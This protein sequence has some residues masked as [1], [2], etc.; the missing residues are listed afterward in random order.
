MREF[1]LITV[2]PGAKPSSFTFSNTSPRFL[3]SLTSTQTLPLNTLWNLIG[4]SLP[5]RDIVLE[6]DFFGS[7]RLF[8]NFNILNWVVQLSHTQ[9]SYTRFLIHGEKQQ[10]AV[11]THG[12]IDGMRIHSHPVMLSKVIH[13]WDNCVV[14]EVQLLEVLDKLFFSQPDYY[15]WTL[16]S[17]LALFLKVFKTA[18]LPLSFSSFKY[19]KRPPQATQTLSTSNSASKM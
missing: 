15:R 14:Y 3:S 16:T 12:D 8:K 9:I 2:P 17:G 7:N 4:P 18:R 19:H 10:A 1:I 5:A 6:V 13:F 11:G